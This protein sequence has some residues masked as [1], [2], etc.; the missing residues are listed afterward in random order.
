MATFIV[1]VLLG[2]ALLW[3]ILRILFALSVHVAASRALG[4]TAPPH[5]MDA[6]HEEPTPEAP[7]EITAPEE[8]IEVVGHAAG[9]SATSA[10]NTAESES[11]TTAP[12]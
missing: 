2:L 7:R 8:Q 4:P 3:L 1:E 10:G 5:S 6:W 11:Q 9:E 12:K